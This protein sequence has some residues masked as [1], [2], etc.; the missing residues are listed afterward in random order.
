MKLWADIVLGQKVMCDLQILSE[1][2]SVAVGLLH[3][4]LSDLKLIWI[5]IF[6]LA[7]AFIQICTMLFIY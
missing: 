2:C 1:H 7:D 6:I 5:L 4:M 3:K